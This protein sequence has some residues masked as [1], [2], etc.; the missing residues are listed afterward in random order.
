VA[1]CFSRL[2]FVDFTVASYSYT[3][4]IRTV[5]HTRCILKE[6]RTICTKEAAIAEER[7]REYP[8]TRRKDRFLESINDISEGF[9]GD[10]TRST[11]NFAVL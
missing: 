9:H 2:S 11:L 7:T 6:I 10:L 5:Q 8:R 4:T 3:E 1:S